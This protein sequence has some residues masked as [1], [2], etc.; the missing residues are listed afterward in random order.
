MKTITMYSSDVCPRCKEAKKFLEEKGYKFVERDVRTDKAV[1]QE[2]R[3]MYV[4][5]F[6]TFV[7]GN[8]IIEGFDPEGIEA[9]MG[10]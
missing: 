8:S 5:G 3:D 2:L 9:A 10:E 7:I 6:P 4:S 1:R